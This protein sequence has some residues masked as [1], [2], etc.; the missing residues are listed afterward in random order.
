M[1][2]YLQLLI[3]QRFVPAGFDVT[4]FCHNTFLPHAQPTKA[5]KLLSSVRKNFNQSELSLYINT[6]T[7]QL[8]VIVSFKRTMKNDLL[9]VLLQYIVSFFSNC[10]DAG[11][12]RLYS[13]GVKTQNVKFLQAY[14][15]TKNCR[16]KS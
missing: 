12:V 3:K 2:Q 1:R 15:F 13:R 7:I 10:G 9:K 16:G 11:R 8:L 14:W 5:E 6:H 4:N